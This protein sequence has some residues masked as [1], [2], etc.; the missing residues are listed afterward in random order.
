MLQAKSSDQR[1]LIA[2]VA[3]S[4]PSARVLG[5]SLCAAKPRLHIG[6]ISAADWSL[7]FAAGAL[8]MIMWWPPTMTFRPTSIGWLRPVLA[9]RLLSSLR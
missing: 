2:S 6:W 9:Y 1:A 3:R 7:V 8:M 4:M 5:V